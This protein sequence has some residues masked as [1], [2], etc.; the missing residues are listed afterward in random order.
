MTTRPRR[1]SAY[2][3]RPA[4]LPPGTH[5]R[6][7]SVVPTADAG[8]E[9][10]SP[11]VTGDEPDRTQRPVVSEPVVVAEP[12]DAEGASCSRTA[13]ARRAGL[14][15]PSSCSP[16]S[17]WWRCW[18]R[19]WAGG[20]SARKVRTRPRRPRRRLRRRSPRPP[21]PTPTPSPTP[22]ASP[23]A[24]ASPSVDVPPVEPPDGGSYLEVTVLDSGDLEVDQWVRSSTP[25]TALRLVGPCRPARR[26]RGRRLRPPGFRRRQR[27]G[28]SHEPGERSGRHHP[29]RRPPG[30]PDLP[31]L[32]CPPALA[33]AGGP[34][35]RA[36][37]RPGSRPQ[38]RAA[39][40]A[41]DDQLP[42]GHGAERD[43]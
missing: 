3:P 4:T 37:G 27:G 18:W 35:A 32:R 28:C 41:H 36:D 17:C 34:R 5:F 26:R 33:V 19:T 7:P 25:L 8:P 10:E 15:S 43:L 23:S 14:G 2:Q 21:T 29:G 42:G 1:P 24:T 6:R 20:S 16:R 39:S 11:V 12:H 38:R 9:S 22:Y 30:A 40:R 31:A 13:G